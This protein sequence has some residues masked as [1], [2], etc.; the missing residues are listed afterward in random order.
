MVKTCYFV[1]SI[2]NGINQKLF[3]KNSLG[4][5]EEEAV[6]DILKMSKEAAKKILLVL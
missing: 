4:C 5:L 6:V 3:F 2:C 1:C